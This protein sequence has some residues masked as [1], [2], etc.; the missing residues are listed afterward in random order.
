MVN[1][2]Y[3]PVGFRFSV[4]FNGNKVDAS[5]VEVTGIST[6]VAVEELVEGGEN[7]FKHRLPSSITHPPLVLKRGYA[8][9]NSALVKWILEMSEVGISDGIKPQSLKVM[10][11]NENGNPITTWAFEGVYPIK[12]EIS[13]LKADAN[14]IVIESIELSYRTFTQ[15][16]DI[17]HIIAAI[18]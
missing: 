13:G 1:L 11:L 16:F 9:F 14:Q 12:Y 17:E 2:N 8:K 10:L 3:P 6:E 18:M 4:D 5:F 15:E 7:R